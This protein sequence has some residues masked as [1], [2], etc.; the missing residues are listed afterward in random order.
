MSALLPHTLFLN[1]LVRFQ[2][3]AIA[4]LAVAGLAGLFSNSDDESKNNR[5]KKN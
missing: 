4:G 3:A 1:I 5:S 2:G